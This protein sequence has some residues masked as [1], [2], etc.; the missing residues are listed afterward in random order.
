LGGGVQAACLA[1]VGHDRDR[2]GVPLL[3]VPVEC[4]LQWRREAAVVLRGDHGE[5]IRRSKPWSQYCDLGRRG[6]VGVGQCL[7][8]VRSSQVD[9]VYVEVGALGGLLGEPVGHRRSE[10]APAGAADDH[11]ES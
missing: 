3:V 8:Q 2:L 5:R 1:T 4:G 10:P 7:G 9:H 6:L 11:C